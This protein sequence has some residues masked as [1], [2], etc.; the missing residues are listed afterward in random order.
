MGKYKKQKFVS[1]ATF[2]ANHLR[3]KQGINKLR[4]SSCSSGDYYRLMKTAY[5]SE[6]WLLNYLQNKER[7]WRINFGKKLEEQFNDFLKVWMSVK[8]WIWEKLKKM[9]PS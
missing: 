9:K 2:V 8:E 5:E 3:M 4:S 6:L 7:H 1:D